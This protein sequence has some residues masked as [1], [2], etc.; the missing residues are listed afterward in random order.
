MTVRLG[1]SMLKD[2]VAVGV[3][4]CRALRIVGP[5]GFRPQAFGYL[6]VSVKAAQ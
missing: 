3:F 1:G 4:Y 5:L 2:R 6:P